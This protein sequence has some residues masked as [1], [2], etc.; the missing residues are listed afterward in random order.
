M[1]ELDYNPHSIDEMFDIVADAVRGKLVKGRGHYYFDVPCA[2]DIETSSFYNDGEKQACMYIWQFGI[3][4]KCIIGRT[5]DEF[6][7]FVDDLTAY[8]GLS[9]EQRL[10]VYVHNLAYEFQWIQHL[11]KWQ[12]VFCIDNR[13]PIYALTESGIEFRCSYLLSGYSLAKLSDNLHIYDVKKLTGD[14]DYSKIRTPITPLTDKELQYCINDVLVVM[15]YIQECMNDDGNITKIPLTKTG[16]V[17]RYCRKRCLNDSDGYKNK[18][19]RYLDLID[20]LQITSID[21]FKALQRA[22]AGGFTHANVLHSNK[23]CYDVSSFDF[24]SSYPTVMVAE[25]FPMSG[26]THVIID[27]MEML[28]YYLDNYCCLFDIEIMGL[29]SKTINDNPLS[30]SKCFVRENAQ[31]N[32]GRVVRADCVAVTITDVDYRIFDRFYSWDSISI[33]DFWV[34]E[35]GYLPTELVSSILYLYQMK[36]TLKGV[37]GKEVEYLHG[38]SMLNAVYGMCVTNPVREDYTYTTKWVHNEINYNAGINKYNLDSKRFLFYPWGVWVTA[39]A[40]RNLFTGIDEFGTDYIYSDTDSIKVLNKE[41]HINYIEAYNNKILDK[42]KTACE[43]HGLDET[44]IAPKTINNEPKPLGVWDYE[45]TYKRFKTLGA[46]RYLI[47][48]ADGSLSLTVS[49]LNKNIAVPFLL[50]TFKDNDGVF[51][52]FQDGLY[53]PPKFTGKNTHTYVDSGCSGTIKDY[54]GVSFDY[55]E[56]SF[57]HLQEADYNLSMASEYLKYL[58]GVAHYV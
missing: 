11:F 54:M 43:Y 22:F 17:R 10:I 5:W 36:T 40:R 57:V 33:G 13:K 52:A 34:Y 2:F 16:Y 30:Y 32:N 14:L 55:N 38:K 27:S 25:Q 15:A 4:G 20:T 49:G 51:N 37:K 21:E 48:R 50:S 29:E 1:I 9:Y 44:E 18:N 6:V 3:A 58:R 42:L 35:R 31:V 28:N 53:I 26:A 7:K 47:E 45:G 39:Y 8:I 24:T 46:K 19:Q 56:R 12:K 23:I 41:Q